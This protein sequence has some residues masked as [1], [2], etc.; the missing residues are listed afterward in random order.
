VEDVA[1]PVV[2]RQD[3]RPV[4]ELLGRLHRIEVEVLRQR[5]AAQGAP[6]PAEDAR[7]VLPVPRGADQPPQRLEVGDLDQVTLAV[8]PL[9]ERLGVAKV[10]PLQER[11]AIQLCRFL[12]AAVLE[13]VV[14]PGDVD[15]DR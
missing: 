5:L 2:D 12:V 8:Q 10:E 6:G 7:S 13:Q 15:V 11:T 14:E 4:V 3:R 1:Q 9:L